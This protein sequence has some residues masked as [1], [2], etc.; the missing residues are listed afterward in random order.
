MKHKEN[1]IE[2]EMGCECCSHDMAPNMCDGNCDDCSCNNGMDWSHRSCVYTCGD[3]G[4]CCPK[5]WFWAIIRI[6][7]V[8]AIVVGAFWLGKHFGKMDNNW[9]RED[10]MMRPMMYGN[11]QY[12]DQM[13]FD[14]SY[15]PIQ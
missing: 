7:I 13:Y 1:N 5:F 3:C 12:N 15:L 2:E 10:R 8:I 6:M 14:N 4:R 11:Q 9:N